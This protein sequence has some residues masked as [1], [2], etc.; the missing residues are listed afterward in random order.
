MFLVDSDNPGMRIER[1]VPTMDH[2]MAGGHCE[3]RFDGCVVP[4]EAIL[5]AVD[6]GFTYAQIRL[7]PARMTHCMR[8][9]GAARRAH[10]IATARAVERTAFGHPLAELGMTQQMIADNEIDPGGLAGA[11]PCGP[12]GTSI[13]ERPARTSTSIGK[14]FVAEA[15]GR[16]VDR[17][18]QMC[19]GLGV[20]EG[21]CRLARIYREVRPFRIYDGPSEVHRWAIARRAARRARTRPA[22]E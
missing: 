15:V 13:P 1:H 19:G 10:D 11:D 14:T 20:A 21:P 2:S 5:G 22:A 4:D 6:E 12:A 17:S 9:L 18:V 16:I 8:W 3:V 7:G